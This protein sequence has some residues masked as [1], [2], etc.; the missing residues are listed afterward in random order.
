MN[1]GRPSPVTTVTTP[2]PGEDSSIAEKPQS[3]TRTNGNGATPAAAHLAELLGAHRG[4]HH[5]IV[6]QNYPDPDAISTAFAHQLISKHFGIETD[7]VYSGKVSHQQNVALLKLLGISLI[8][9]SPALDVSQYAGAVFVDNQGTTSG[10]IVAA[11]EAAGVPTLIVVDHHAVQDRLQATFTD[12][13]RTGATA[14][15]YAEYLQAGLVDL[16]HSRRE[17]QVVATALLHG[18]LTDSGDFVRANAEDFEAAAFLSAFRDAEVLAQIMSQARSKQTMEVIRRALG[19]RLT[20]ESF[21][22]AGIGYLRAEDRDAI[23]QAAD[24]LLTEENVHTAIVYGIVTNDGEE[25]LI[26]SMRTSKLTLD[27]DSFIKDTLGKNAAGQYFGGGKA[28]AAGFE[29]PIGFLSGNPGDEYREL[30]WQAYDKQVKHKLL[31]KLGVEPAGVAA[32]AAQAAAQ[33]GVAAAPP[34]KPAGPATP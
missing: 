7:M 23:P 15:I 24:F 22:I 18:L 34:P 20:V 10:Q 32:P 11:L 2:W 5:M 1:G 28:S 8:A 6:L 3:T 16:D 4:E 30:K 31:A 25:M 27:P 13:R 26:G 9:F 17:H 29:V 12:I 33:P 19:Y 14:T 21:S